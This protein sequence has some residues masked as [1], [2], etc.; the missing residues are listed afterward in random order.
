MGPEATVRRFE[1]VEGASSKF[2][3]VSISGS[4][5]TV[6]YG[7]LGA[8]GTAK[9][10]DAGSP[11]AAA[12]EVDKLIR[13]KTRKG[14]AEIGGAPAAWRPPAGY[15]HLEH[16]QRF[17]N[18]PVVD[19]RPDGAEEGDS[20]RRAAV[21]LSDLDRRVYAIGVSYEDDEAQLGIRVDALLADRRVGELKGLVIGSWFTEYDEEGPSELVA[22]LLADAAKLTSLRGL[23]FGDIVQEESEIS[24][25]H[26]AD[27]G[28]LLNA[29]P[30]LEEVVVRGGDGL[31]FTG[32]RHASLRALHVQ[33]GG[34]G[35]EA[36]RDLLAAELPELR[37]LVLWL[38]VDDYGATWSVA[39]LAPLLAGGLFPKLEHLGLMNNDASDEIAAAVAQAPLLGRLRGLDLSMGTLGDEGAE[40]LLASPAVRGLSWLGLR[41]SYL[42]DDVA[43][44]LR[45]L[46]IEVDLRDRQDPDDDRYVEVSE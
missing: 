19:L 35:V 44:R 30:A 29:L 11:A 39:D 32:L 12:A 22:R 41:R 4:S 2:W 3:E 6:R 21:S 37:A 46:G 7:R 8:A 13:E 38:G 40:A 14:Y 27:L 24:W 31:R 36:L 34:L 9:T 18:F 15:P 28:P 26:Q 42:S 43:R 45:G 1:L 23:F 33:T 10:T 20:G 16:V 25:L 17:M 5:F